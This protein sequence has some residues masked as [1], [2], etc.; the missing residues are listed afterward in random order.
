MKSGVCT[1]IVIMFQR[2]SIWYFIAYS[3][4]ALCVQEQYKGWNISYREASKKLFT[5]CQVNKLHRFLQYY[6][7]YG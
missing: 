5:L 6:L 4:R 1:W 2:K 3:L 7:N